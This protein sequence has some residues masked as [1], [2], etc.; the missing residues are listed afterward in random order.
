MS[1]VDLVEMQKSQRE[2]TNISILIIIAS[3]LF[4]FHRSESLFPS[5]IL[6]NKDH[7]ET[8]SLRNLH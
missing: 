1:E 2:E 5:S 6:F 4:G 7:T 3:K 8:L